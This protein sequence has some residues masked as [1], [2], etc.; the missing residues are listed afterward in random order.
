[1]R[2]TRTFTILGLA[3]LLAV[4]LSA[5]ALARSGGGASPA[6]QFRSA[7]AAKLGAQIGKPA[8]AVQAALKAVARRATPTDRAAR[9]RKRARRL[10]LRA[11]ALARGVR[12]GRA[13]RG[14]GAGQARWAAAL[15]KQLGV[16][17]AK[18]DA[19]LRAVVAEQLDSLVKQGWIT[20]AQ[21]DK[22]L[23]RGAGPALLRRLAMIRG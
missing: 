11:Q 21:R 17:A 3:G 18:V 7:L 9:L 5:L 1:M 8:D 22:R 10:Q 20:P 13:G 19:A 4:G 12:P 16:P 23:Q 14:R 15:A 2:R 6:H